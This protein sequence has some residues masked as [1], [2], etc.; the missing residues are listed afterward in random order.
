MSEAAA[1]FGRGLDGRYTLIEMLG[2]GGQ[3]EVWRARDGSRGVDIALKL[4]N[5]A[6]ARK[7]TIWSGLEREYAISCRLEHPSILKVFAPELSGDVMVLPMELAA[8][9]D[10]RRLRGAGFLEIIPVLL[11]V[12]HALEHAHE[13][14]VVHRDLK[15]GNVL[16]NSR[17][18][19]LL[20]D[21]GVAE[22]AITGLEVSGN[23]SQDSLRGRNQH[24]LSPFTASPQQLRGEPPTAADDI[25]GLG[26]LAYEL[27]SGYP[28]FYPHF[29]RRRCIEAPV[30]DL[31]PTR[32]I[33]PLFGALVMRML[34][35]DP[36]KRPGSMR[37]VIDELD[38][39]LNDTLTFDYERGGP[40]AILAAASAPAPTPTPARAPA[41]ACAP[42]PTPAAASPASIPA[43]ASTSGAAHALPE[44][45][46]AASNLAAPVSVA[47]WSP[48]SGSDR[49]KIADRRARP[50]MEPVLSM[51][52]PPPQAP[53][54]AASSEPIL[55]APMPS[56]AALSPARTEP[57]PPPDRRAAAAALMDV[58]AGASP[59]PSARARAG[60]APNSS[61]GT[62]GRIE[63]N[64]VPPSPAWRA[65]PLDGLPRVAR[66]QPI[67][68][69]RWPWIS[70]GILTG[71]AACAYFWLPKVDAASLP[72]NLA[73]VVSPLQTAIS[74]LPTLPPASVAAPDGSTTT[75]PGSM[76]PSGSPAARP[77]VNTTASTAATA[78]AGGAA[79]SG[80]DDEQRLRALRQSF[81]ARLAAVEARGAGV[82]GG[83][84][85]AIAKTRAAESV[86]AHDA[87]NTKI[88]LER[89]A[90]AM[91]LLEGVEARAPQAL[92]A[93]LAAGE[94]ALGT[95]QQEVAGQ[96]FELARRIDPGDRRAVEG[97]RRT[98]NLNGVLPLLADA[99]NAEAAHDYAR[100]AQDYSQALSLDPG[101]TIARSGQ[102]RANAAFGDDSYAKM[103]GSGFAALGAG[104]LDQAHEAFVKARALKPSGPEALEGLKRVGAALTARGFASMR[105]RGAALESQERWEEAEQTYD[106]VL[107]A[108]P[109]LA[110]AQ[111]GKARAGSR[112]ELAGRLQQLIERP[113]RLGSPG[114]RD[115][116]RSLL[117]TAEAQSPQGPV[118]RAQVARL[119]GLLPGIDRPVRL[120]LLSDNST[121]VA[122][123]SIGSFGAFSR[124]EIELRPGRYTVVGTRNGFRDVRREITVTP[125]QD[126][127][128]IRVSCSDPI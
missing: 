38:A 35:K 101:N 112:A 121:Q 64:V 120:S 68:P 100:A 11:E 91:R 62:P 118:L 47:V 37:E 18:R 126:A 60:T 25:Y 87:G 10:L 59:G 97:Q 116:A 49:R 82:W 1:A 42:T 53:P 21:F 51:P 12:A 26:A 117:E 34:A 32:Q 125:G 90:A 22:T 96:A 98:Q 30:P 79:A 15:P 110:F 36:R 13:R 40:A 106:D 104:R 103:V 124:R 99:Q 70:L 46:A 19:A 83:R 8:G 72:P 80:T 17:G 63:V 109:S 56:V 3:G 16:F 66:L 107:S 43:Q 20:A 9:G 6:L 93:Q 23:A 61:G 95:G 5:P 45:P 123:P 127:Q 113:E 57:P 33:P 54:V 81:D 88:A 69:R 128:T 27:L 28:P 74:S 39:A 119:Q 76:A 55:V 48:E 24:G 58:S 52:E 50:R 71:I 84:D 92:N 85:F 75:A 67:R 105:Q 89:L 86:G 73:A 31:V 29:D 94:K 4:M 77:A 108:D 78:L 41:W 102:A 65:I 111:E 122:I 44:E 114:A 7:E 14:G 2:A 115:E